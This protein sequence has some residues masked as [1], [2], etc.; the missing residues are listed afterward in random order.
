MGVRADFLELVIH[1]QKQHQ[2]ILVLR[3]E[4]EHLR[5]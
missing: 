4:N 5:A 2:E 1:Y 3:Q